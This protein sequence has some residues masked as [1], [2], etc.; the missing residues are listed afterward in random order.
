LAEDR[1]KRRIPMTMEDWTRRLD[2]FL[3]ADDRELLRD[4]GKISAQLAREFAENE[5][6]KFRIIQ[7]RLFKSDFDKEM[8][9]IK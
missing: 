8:K 9:K 7:D 6:E 2:A 3:E 1:A 5:F 4:N